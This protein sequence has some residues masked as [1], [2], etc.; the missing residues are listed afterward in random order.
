MQRLHF[1]QFW[2]L[3]VVPAR[4]VP[5]AEH[6]TVSAFPPFDAAMSTAAAARSSGMVAGVVAVVA[7]GAASGGAFS[8]AWLA[9]EGAER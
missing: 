2:W 5:H 3:A 6:D 1:C 9:K 8:A 4:C 7:V